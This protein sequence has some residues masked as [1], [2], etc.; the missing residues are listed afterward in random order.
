M[1][2][3]LLVLKELFITNQKQ[4]SLMTDMK[5]KLVEPANL[6]SSNPNLFFRRNKELHSALS[7]S[8]P[9]PLRSG[10][11]VNILLWKVYQCNTSESNFTEAQ[12]LHLWSVTVLFW[13]GYNL[14]AIYQNHQL[15]TNSKKKKKSILNILSYMCCSQLTI[16]SHDCTVK[17]QGISNQPTQFKKGIPLLYLFTFFWMRANII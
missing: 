7:S 10:Q 16:Y 3:R 15:T 6:I 14:S 9:A 1:S 8:R 5:D 12:D 11:W 13:P 4:F 2:R 17:C